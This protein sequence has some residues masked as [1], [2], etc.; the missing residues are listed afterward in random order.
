[1]AFQFEPPQA[2]SALLLQEA[3]RRAPRAATDRGEAA[4]W[5]QRFVRSF[6]A[7]PAMA[8][9]A[10][11]VLVITAA[12]TLYLRG[13]NQ[14]ARPEMAVIDR[15][16]A[17]SVP[18]GTAPASAPVAAHGPA[19]G[20][21]AANAPGEPTGALEGAS[22]EQAADPGAYRARLDGA[23]GGGAGNALA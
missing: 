14:L 1:L 15:A 17:S 21:A 9:A 12:G 18:T 7:H 5:F 6:T 23:P 13:A 8:A 3:S 10:T 19:A 16:P 22:G 11:L 2:I 20:S 4:T